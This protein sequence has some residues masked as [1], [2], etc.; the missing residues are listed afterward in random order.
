MNSLKAFLCKSITFS[1]FSTMDSD[2][3]KCLK[4]FNY[5]GVVNFRF[6][7]RTNRLEFFKIRNYLVAGALLAVLVLLQLYYGIG[8]IR[9]TIT[10]HNIRNMFSIVFCG[11]IQFQTLWK[12][13]RIVRLCQSLIKIDNEI[14]CFFQ[15]DSNYRSIY[16]QASVK[17]IISLIYF[18]A[19]ASKDFSQSKQR[20]AVFFHIILN[21]QA[22]M[23]S[24]LWLEFLIF[25]A[26][27]INIKY[28][29]LVKIC[30]EKFSQQTLQMMK[31]IM[32]K[33]TK[34]KKDLNKAFQKELLMY[35]FLFF[36]NVAFQVNFLIGFISIKMSL[37]VTIT[38]ELLP[39]CVQFILLAKA[40]DDL[41]IYV[42]R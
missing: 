15:K 37:S 8:T 35:I 29:T 13:K 39:Y 40:L 31:I 20:F 25:L 33:I 27:C 32:L 36:I 5:L 18:L 34:A 21:F 7:R 30:E 12:T 16:G 26:N 2:Y 3:K 11:Y 23:I 22:M 28:K 6:N 42:N 19:I 14:F 24:V 10:L 1:E 41:V 38:F 17:C 9:L 4:L